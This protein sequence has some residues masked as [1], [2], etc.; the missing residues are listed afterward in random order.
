MQK[1]RRNCP[2]YYG[3]AEQTYINWMIIFRPLLDYTKEELLKIPGVG[4]KVAE[5]YLGILG[6]K[7][8]FPVDTHVFRVSHKLGL[9]KS[10]NAR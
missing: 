3:I 2:K 8:Y 10:D 7:E 4:V 1:R 5:V 6:S 9:S